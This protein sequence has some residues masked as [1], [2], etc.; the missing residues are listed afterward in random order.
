MSLVTFMNRLSYCMTRAFPAVQITFHE[1][2]CHGTDR[3]L[4]PQMHQENHLMNIFLPFF[5]LYKWKEQPCRA[6]PIIIIIIIFY[7]SFPYTSYFLT[8]GKTTGFVNIRLT[9]EFCTFF[10]LLFI[11]LKFWWFISLLCTVYQHLSHHSYLFSNCHPLL[12]FRLT[13][14]GAK[15]VSPFCFIGERIKSQT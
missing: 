7:W 15:D 2:F 6:V 1:K 4:L 3:T 11:F 5:A 9:L 14:P 10:Q 8:R 13:H 12:S